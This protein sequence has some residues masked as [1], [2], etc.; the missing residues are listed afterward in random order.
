[1]SVIEVFFKIFDSI[2]RLICALVVNFDKISN[3]I[4]SISQT[5]DNRISYFR[6]L[7]DTV[8]SRVSILI[9]H[10]SIMLAVLIFAYTSYSDK[11]IG[12]YLIR[13]E[14][15]AYLVM[16]AILIRCISAVSKA[17]SESQSDY[18]SEL[19]AEAK[20]RYGYFRAMSFYSIVFTFFLVFILMRYPPS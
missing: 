6:E 14:I 5:E 20:L 7:I 1:M 4:E 2:A 16:T 18:E 8:Q 11:G 10:V 9:G 19:V 12:A 3:R 13:I 15:I 17:G